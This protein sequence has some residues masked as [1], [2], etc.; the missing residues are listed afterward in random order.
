MTH[1][2]SRQPR[3]R[4]APPQ[5]QCRALIYSQADAAHGEQRVTLEEASVEISAFK[6]R[7]CVEKK[8]KKLNHS[9]AH[10]RHQIEAL[11]GNPMV[12]HQPFH[13]TH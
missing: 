13:G 12:I 11:R 1:W 8:I 5:R 3:N 7:T 9:A 10:D 6:K 4:G 2:A